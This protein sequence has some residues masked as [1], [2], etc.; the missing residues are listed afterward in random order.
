MLLAITV[1]ALQK[2]R[3]V[4]LMEV[5]GTSHGQIE[6]IAPNIPTAG[7][8]GRLTF[9]HKH[10]LLESGLVVSTNVGIAIYSQR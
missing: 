7:G 8:D 2:E 10:K 4:V 1:S 9:H 3:R 6:M 5:L